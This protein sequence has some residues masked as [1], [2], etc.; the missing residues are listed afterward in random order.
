MALGQLTN[1][2]DGWSPISEWI[3]LATEKA[4]G[5]IFDFLVMEEPTDKVCLLLAKLN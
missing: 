5:I 1:S 3:A 4:V 2:S